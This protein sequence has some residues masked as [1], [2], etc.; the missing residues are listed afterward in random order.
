MFPKVIKAGAGPHDFGSGEN[1][2]ETLPEPTTQLI[3]DSDTGSDSSGDPTTDYSTLIT[4]YDSGLELLS[5]PITSYDSGRELFH[6]A[7][8]VGRSP[9]PRSSILTSPFRRRKTLSMSSRNMSS[10]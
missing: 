6:N 9:P 4:S 8:S 7:S 5:S 2:G 1:H 10:R 3:P